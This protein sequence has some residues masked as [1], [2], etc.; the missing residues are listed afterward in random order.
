MIPQVRDLKIW[1]EHFAALLDGSKPFEV[2]NNDRGYRVGDV[3]ELREWEPQ[4]GKRGYTGRSTFRTVTYIYAGDM[5]AA[6][7]VVLGLAAVK[8]D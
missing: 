4:I 8:K 3:L 6:G 2:R 5:M 1:P 7:Y